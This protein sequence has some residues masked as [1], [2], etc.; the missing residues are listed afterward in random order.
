MTLLRITVSGEAL[1]SALGDW[2]LDG[3]Q[4]R[5]TLDPALTLASAAS[6]VRLALL[7]SPAPWVIVQGRAAAPLLSA[8]TADLSL[9][10]AG[11]FL[12]TPQVWSTRPLELAPLPFP[13]AL[14]ATQP[15][16]ASRTHAKAWGAILLPLDDLFAQPQALSLIDRRSRQLARASGPRLVDAPYAAVAGSA[17]G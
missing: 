2:P 16:R 4:H 12:L 1:P 15:D 13:S 11:A 14:V 9:A 6:A 17:P 3:P 10:V 5:L 7:A 8:V